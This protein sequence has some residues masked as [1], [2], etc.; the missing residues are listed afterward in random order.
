MKAQ[1]A[2]IDFSGVKD[3]DL[4]DDAQK[5]V[6]KMTGN[7]NYT[8][9]QPS[10]SVVQSAIT[11]YSAAVIKSKDGTKEDT[12]NKN[13]T[14]LVLQDALYTLGNYVNMTAESNLVKLESSGFS[15]SKLPEAVGILDAPTL[16][17]DYGKNPGELIIDIDVVPRATEYLVL[18]APVPAPID[19]KEYYSQL[20]SKTKGLLTHLQSGTRY[21]LKAAATSSEA[22]K[23]GEYNFSDPV[24]KLVP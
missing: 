24:E 3:G 5:I 4:A 18:Y 15:I 14:R 11:A 7:L 16:H 20:F 2:L 13:A 9:P 10:L 19:D 21:V 6:D 12:A 1:K 23:M 22:N 8:A 17:V